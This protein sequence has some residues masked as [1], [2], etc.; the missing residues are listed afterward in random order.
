MVSTSL[1]HAITQSWTL[2]DPASRRLWAPDTIFGGFYMQK[3][4]SRMIVHVLVPVE[5]AK[6]NHSTINYDNTHVGTWHWWLVHRH[7]FFS[8]TPSLV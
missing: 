5:E 6:L 8:L 1:F 4:I 3:S 7:N 2:L